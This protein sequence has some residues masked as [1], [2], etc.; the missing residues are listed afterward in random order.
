MEEL[1][2]ALE[3]GK[4]NFDGEDINYDIATIEDVIYVE[5]TK[6]KEV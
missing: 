5:Y 6:I 3:L 2:K 1:I 4:P